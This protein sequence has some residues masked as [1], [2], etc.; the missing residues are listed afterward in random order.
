MYFCLF[1]KQRLNA[2]F[3]SAIFLVFRSNMKGVLVLQRCDAALMNESVG[4]EAALGE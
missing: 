4:A 1:R 2:N 3:D